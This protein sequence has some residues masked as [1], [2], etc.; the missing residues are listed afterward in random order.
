LHSKSRALGGGDDHFERVL[1]ALG[2]QISDIEPGPNEAIA[3]HVSEKRQERF[4][5]T[6]DVGD[7]DRLFVP[8]ELGPCH[9]LDELLQG[10]DSP[11]Q[12]D[13]GIGLL[14][15]HAFARVHVRDDVQFLRLGQHEFP[16]LEKLGYDSRHLPAGV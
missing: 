8:A 12:R 5:E 7:Q 10:A 2:D 1:D 9:L 6:V 13:E 16:G 11:G 14:E 4:P 3:A 15:H